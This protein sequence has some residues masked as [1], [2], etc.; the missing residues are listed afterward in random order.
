MLQRELRP[1]RGELGPL[2]LE[3]LARIYDSEIAL[4]D[5]L[6]EEVLRRLQQLGRFDDALIVITADHGEEFLD[7]GEIGHAKSLY[8]EL[9]LVPLLVK[10]PDG[11]SGGVDQ[12]IALLDVFPTILDVARL[13][14]PQD[15]R[16]RSLPHPGEEA[17][18][19]HPVFMET[20]RG[21]N[22]RGIVLGRHKLIHDLESGQSQLYHLVDDPREGRDLVSEEPETA[23]A[24]LRELEAWMRRNPARQRGRSAL[25]LSDEEKQRLRDLGYL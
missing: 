5:S 17:P 2:D 12:P 7:H 18:A 24:L 13:Q 9:V 23:D 16:G 20:S 1:M 6:I 25:E 22:L 15:L 10:F 21:G 8:D 11:V 14:P 4:T 3:E 19:E